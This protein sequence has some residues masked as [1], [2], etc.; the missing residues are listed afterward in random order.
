MKIVIAGPGAIGLLFAAYLSKSKEDIWLLDKDN[1]RA[2]K[3]NLEGISINGVS[4]AWQ[5]KVRVCAN[6]NEIGSCDLLIVCV[7][8]Y[9]TK[10][11][12]NYIRP[13]IDTNSS[14]LTLQNGIGNMEL[15]S[16]VF[17]RQDIFVGVTSQGANLLEVGKLSHAG[18][19]DTVIGRIDSKLTSQ[20]REIRR[21]FNEVGIPTRLSRDIK[22]VL[23][24]KLIINVG[25]NSL[26]AIT[27]LRNGQLL[28]FD[29]A[30]QI[31]RQAVAEAVKIAKR[32]RIKLQFDDPLAKVEAVCLAT[33]NNTCSM[34]ADVLKKKHTEIDFINGVIVRYA[35]GMGIPVPVNN[36]LVDLIKTIESSYGLKI[37]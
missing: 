29:G 5:A 32:K 1:A 6:P 7:K 30:R 8:S 28:E 26:A 14:I 13:L 20:L 21:I 17:N 18:F 3:L 33:A 9:D 31:M 22:G 15:I 34:L 19:G 23:W 2:E 16:E 24:S 36:F 35:Q 27:R 12:I 4:G 25:I 11:L 37:D 10:K